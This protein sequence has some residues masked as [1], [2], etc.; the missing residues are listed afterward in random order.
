M[1]LG[2]D[3]DDTITNTSEVV[4]KYLKEE[5]PYYDE[6][7]LLSRKEYKK[8]LKKY[9]K[10]MRNDYGLK[11]GIQEAWAYFQEH[12]FKIIIITARNKK[13]DRD[14]L[15][16]TIA[17]LKQNGLFYDKIYFKKVKKGKTAYKERVDLFIDDKENVL[18][19]VSSYG[20]NCIC[21]GNSKKY[22]SFCNWHQVLQYIKEEYHG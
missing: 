10:K 15:K 3:I 16:N 17:F 7:H 9:I 11:E 20:I 13:Y 18:D 22:Q 4:Q 19:E 6:S 2:I 1:I 8:F 12:H 14:N 21:M 5:Y